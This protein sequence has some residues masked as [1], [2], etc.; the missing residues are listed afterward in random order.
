MDVKW[1]VI[2]I[3][4][5]LMN[6][7]VEHLFMCLLVIYISDGEMFFQFLC[8]FVNQAFVV[9]ELWVAYMVWILN[10]Y[11]VYELKIFSPIW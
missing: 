6:S 7:D 8:P 2:M 9:V 10:P 4:I 3:L 5:S 11:Y 1:Y